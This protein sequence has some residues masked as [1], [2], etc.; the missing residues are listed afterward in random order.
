MKTQAKTTP[1][2]WIGID[3]HKKTWKAHFRTDLF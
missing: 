2:L 1:K 3:F